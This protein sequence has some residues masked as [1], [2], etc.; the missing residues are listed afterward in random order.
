MLTRPPA[1]I[2]MPL[3]AVDTPALLLD[4]EAFERNLR[5]L[6]DAIA[7]QPVRLRPHAKTHKCPMIARRQ[8]ALGAVGVC[9]QKVSE[10]E[11]MVYGG[12]S[13]ILVSNEVVGA[14]K[15][16]RLAALAQ[17]AQMYVC[18]DQAQNVADLNDVALAYNV[19]LAVLVEVNVGANRCG[20][21][22]GNPA[23]GLA[24]QIDTAP[25]LRFAGLQAYH[26]GAQHIRDFQQRREA[27]ATAVESVHHTRNILQQHGLECE[28]VTGAGTG[29]YP[30]EAAS[31]VYNELQ[32]GSY[33]FMDADYAKN[34]AADSTPWHE[35]EH[36][37]FIYATVMSRPNNE[38]AVVDAGLKALSV[39]SGLPLVY[40]A[41][42]V[43]YS[44]ASD[45][46]GKLVFHDASHPLR[47]GDK[48][49]L[50]PGHCD[51]TVNLYDW[52]VGIRNQRVEA[53]WPITAR[54]ALL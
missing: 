52:Y 2:G 38:W 54:G 36:S 17:Q 51:P 48:I 18:A 45:E 1:E 14:P 33:V 41:A 13:N 27:I 39:D 25:G 50:I 7:D 53:L 9:C 21:E 47:V 30:F 20:V 8:M 10:A 32:A 3:E 5:H 37:L 22:P 23:L 44:R 49:R 12:V 6:A 24:Q 19:Q 16:H 11:A 15:L 40:G 29:T 26:G 42:G 28:L 4:L 34:L 43:E 31:H 46:H 35:F